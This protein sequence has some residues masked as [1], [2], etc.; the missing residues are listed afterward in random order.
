MPP[1]IKASSTPTHSLRS[2]T[3]QTKQAGHTSFS[4]PPALLGN[5]CGQGRQKHPCRAALGEVRRVKET[6]M[7]S[8]E[9]RNMSDPKSCPQFLRS[10]TIQSI[11]M[12]SRAQEILKLKPQKQKTGSEI[13]LYGK[14]ENGRVAGLTGG[15]MP[16]SAS[17]RKR[18]YC[19]HAVFSCHFITRLC[20]HTER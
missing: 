7:R 1:W 15:W 5:V 10:S 6:Q 9:D 14:K 8:A 11:H 4:P 3:K 19:K 2:S 20:K 18:M 17:S 13:E 12:L 16:C